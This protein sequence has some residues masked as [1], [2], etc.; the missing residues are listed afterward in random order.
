M[1]RV[2]TVMVFTIM[3][4]NLC[5]YGQE[6][7]PVR[8]INGK[9]GFIDDNSGRVVIP[10]KYSEVGKFSEGLARV[11]YIS[12]IDGFKYWDFID[13][14]GEMRIRSRE[15]EN[16]GDF[17]EGLARIKYNGKWGFIDK[18]GKIVIPFIYNEAK[19]F[20]G[21]TALVRINNNW[22]YIDKTG[23]GV[24]KNVS[25]ERINETKP[26]PENKIQTA[27]EMNRQQTQKKPFQGLALL[28][29]GH[30]GTAISKPD[31]YPRK[32]NFSKNT[33]WKIETNLYSAFV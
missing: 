33:F 17:S 11:S 30:G 32:D 24:I 8:D 5:S 21:G 19:D 10:F 14:T 2:V 26:Q 22:K 29:S 27:S 1:K 18:S 3:T 16:A 7:S 23:K 13:K 25:T 9:W 4:M 12:S 31:N 20:S 6:L 28:V 15:F